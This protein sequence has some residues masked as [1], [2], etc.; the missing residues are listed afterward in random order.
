MVLNGLTPR[1]R[2]SMTI[3]RT[4]EYGAVAGDFF[5]QE[6]PALYNTIVSGGR[7]SDRSAVEMSMIELA[8]TAAPSQAEI[9][10]GGEKHPAAR[11]RIH[12][13]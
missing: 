7:Q 11:G 2:K 8:R 1:K 9:L 13:V 3:T 4:D 6:Q 12:P 10:P 5:R